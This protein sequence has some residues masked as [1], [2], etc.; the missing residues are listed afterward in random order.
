MGFEKITGQERAVHLL[1]SAMAEGRLHHAYR[2]EGP[3]GT[4][5]TMTA[6]AMA[7]TLN[8]LSPV[9][10]SLPPDLGG[11]AR[12][13]TAF[14]GACRSC[15]RIP[16]GGD[17][18]AL[19]HPDVSVV[20]AQGQSRVIKIEQIREIQSTV[21]YAPSDGKA[22]V[23]VIREADNITEA[24]SNAFLKL[25]EE[26]PR[27][28]YF[29]LTTS[30]PHKLLPTLRSRTT[31]IRFSPLPA[32]AI[33]SI[34]EEALPGIDPRRIALAAAVSGGSVSRA[35]AYA[36]DEGAAEEALNF[37]R[38]F[39]TS[40]TLDP[41]AVMDLLDAVGPGKGGIEDILNLLGIYYRDV[42]F[43]RET[44]SGEGITLTPIAEQ[45]VERAGTLDSETAV[46]LSWKVMEGLRLLE[47]NVGPRMILEKIVFDVRASLDLQARSER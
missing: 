20:S 16:V 3:P 33:R 28:T 9:E 38:K 42:A 43:V 45:V 23:L 36:E 39:D 11:P 21:A 22:R 8:C 32:A 29:F 17:L 6:M 12:R 13:L 5:K 15:R 47:A 26:P 25:L 46:L 40:L 4:G 24:A 7:A 2:F 35:R 37:V 18:E 41:K 27:D 44:G 1:A 31:V 14:C 19:D 30:R 34:L 10:S